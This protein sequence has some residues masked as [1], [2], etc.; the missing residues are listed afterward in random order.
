MAV[1]E[2]GGTQCCFDATELPSNHITMDQKLSL[3]DQP[4]TC[5][6]AGL[7][8]MTVDIV[9]YQP[10]DIAGFQLV[11]RRAA[12]KNV[13]AVAAPEGSIAVRDSAVPVEL[14]RHLRP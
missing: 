9:D 2:V 13:V 11:R 7:L 12:L 4:A 6:G 3:Y 14:H 1:G 8:S 5:N 10:L